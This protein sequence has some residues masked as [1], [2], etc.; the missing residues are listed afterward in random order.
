MS[1]VT[2]ER[3][4][5]GGKPAQVETDDHV[6]LQAQLASGAQGTIEAARVFR[7]AVNDFQI[8]I[9][10]SRASLRW[11]MMNPNY[12]YRGDDQGWLEI[13][14]VQ[15]YPD[16]FLPG[17]DVPAGLMRYH[18]ASAAAF[19]RLTLAGQAYDP[20]LA[21]GARVQA[22]IQAAVEASRAQAWVSVPALET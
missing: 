12:L 9:Y 15:T 6:I 19:L 20:G 2:K 14:T 16:A 17:A 11:N 21:Q 22:V 3:P 4:G 18:I 13:P 10:G 7:G 1:T 5:E 8:E